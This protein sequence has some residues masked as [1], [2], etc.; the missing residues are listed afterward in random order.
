MCNAE[1]RVERIVNLFIFC[2]ELGT[3]HFVTSSFVVYT[4]T[5]KFSYQITQIAKLLSLSINYSISQ[6]S[7]QSIDP[8]YNPRRLFPI[9]SSEH[10]RIVSVSRFDIFLINTC[11]LLYS[12][13]PTASCHV[14]TLQRNLRTP[15]FSIYTNTELLKLYLSSLT[16]SSLD[17]ADIG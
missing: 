13:R 6:Q 14:T 10:A 11:S 7:I 15:Y 1:Q 9:T 17:G 3:L 12:I 2:A 16:L 8:G 4:L 5:D